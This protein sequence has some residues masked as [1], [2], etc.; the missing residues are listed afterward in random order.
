MYNIKKV[1][2]KGCPTIKGK[3]FLKE[4]GEFTEPII[5][6]HLKKEIK[7]HDFYFALF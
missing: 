6:N 4:D 7:K 1:V 2:L 5:A 3:V